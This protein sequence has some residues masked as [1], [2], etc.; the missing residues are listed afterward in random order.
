MET[1]L[2][3]IL[4]F[5]NI[6]FVVGFANSQL[7]FHKEVQER[8]HKKNDE[9][10]SEIMAKNLR[11]LSIKDCKPKE[12]AH[13]FVWDAQNKVAVPVNYSGKKEVWEAT[14]DKESRF[15]HFVE[16]PIPE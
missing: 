5:L 2:F 4:G 14:K 9:L 6:I 3:I 12:G 8:Y 13:I 10:L 15:T 7:K 1:V 11:F 16:L